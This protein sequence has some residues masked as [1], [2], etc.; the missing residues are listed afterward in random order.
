MYYRFLRTYILM[1]AFISATVVTLHGQP[2]ADTQPVITGA[3]VVSNNQMGVI[4]STP[5]IP[6]HTYAW[7]VTGGSVTSG[8]GTNQITVSWGSVG[9]GNLS[10]LETN[11]AASCSSTVAKSVVIQPLLIS[12]FYYTNTSCYGDV[13]SFWDSSVSDAAMPITNYYWT[14]GDGIT[15]TLQN[16]VH[17]YAG[18]PYN[19]TYNVMLVV[20]NSIGYKDTIYDAV[21]VNPNQFIP[22][23]Q[24]SS[25]IP[26]CTYQPVS[27]NSSAS[28]T[29]P[30]TGNIIHWDWNFGNPASGTNNTSN[31]ANPTHVFTSPGTYTVSMEITNERYCKAM[32]TQQVV[33]LESVPVAKYVY[34]SPTCLGNPVY[35]TNQS[36]FPTGKDIVRWIWDFADGTSPVVIDA[37]SNPN[38]VHIF[39]GLGPYHVQLKVINTLG[40]ADSTYKNIG[41]DP[42]PNSAFTQD[43]QCFGDTVKFTDAS[44]RN[45]GPVITSYYWNFDDTGSGFFNTST[46]QNPT[47]KFSAPGIFDIMMVTTNASGCPDTLIKTIEIH[48]SP[49]V[50]F[51]WTLG[52]ENNEV[53]F[54]IDPSVTNLNIIGNM[55]LWNF[56]DGS[57]GYG[58]NPIH[59]YLAGGYFDVTCTVTDTLGCKG[60]IMHTILIPS[61][62]VAF[63]AT[64]SPVCD[65]DSICVTDLSSVPTPPFGFIKTWI[66]D[67]G[68]G[69][70]Q[71]TVHFPDP[72]N[73]CHLYS[74][75]DTFT[76]TL[77]VIDNSGFNDSFT[78]NVIVL[79]NPVANFFTT[80]ACQN[81]IVQ[82]TD[83]ST[84]NGGGNVITWDWNFGDPGSGVNNTAGIPTPIHSFS[85]GDSIYNVRL[86]ITNFTGCSDTITKQVYVFPAPPVDFTF[87]TACLN[88]I[89]TFNAN[90]GVTHIDSIVTWS[91]N[92]GDGTPL[93]TDPVTTQHLYTSVGNFL[94]TLTV[95]DHHGCVNTISHM[96]HVNPLP[97][98]DFTWATPNCMGS[99]LQFTDLSYVPAPYL[100]YI[101]KWK[102][103]FGDGTPIQTI[104]IPGNPSL[105]HTFAG[106]ATNHTVR[107]TVWTGD[108]CTAFIE[109]VVTSLPAPI[110]N[111][112]IGTT[113][114]KDQVVQFTDLSQPNG[115][116]SIASWIWDFGDPASGG[117]NVSPLPSPTHIYNT[118]GVTYNVR[119]IVHNTNTCIDT[120]IK[121]VFIRTSP[122]VDFTYDTA[123]LNT[124]VH[125]NAN[126]GLTQIDSIT[127]WS[128]N[129]GD[130]SG[131][132]TDPVTTSH[133]YANVG[134]YVTTLT[135][136]DNHG[137]INT[138]SHTVKVN[139][140]PVPN[141]S[142]NAPV[143][144]SAVVHFTDLSTVI[145]GYVAKW[146]WDFNDGSPLLTVFIPTSPNVIHIFQGTGNTHV[147]R[148][149]VW[150]ND[151]CTEFIEKTVISIP[152]PIAIFDYAT[153]TCANQS[154]Q[155]NDFSQTNGGGNLMTWNWNFG[156][157]GSG[158]GNISALQNP[159]HLYFTAGTYS[160]TLIVT[161]SSDCKD[162][163]VRNI[164]INQLPIANFQADTVCFGTPTTFTDLS[165]PQSLNIVSYSWSFGDA[166]PPGTLPNPTHTYGAPGVYT[167]TLTIINSNGCT[168]DTSHLIL[169]NPLPTA[170]F[171]F[172]TPNCQGAIVSYTDYSTTPTGYI[173]YINKWVWNF[174]DGSP[175]V[176]INFPASPDITHTFTGVALSHPVTLTVTTTSGCVHSITHIVNSVPAPVANFTFST[177]NCATQ[178]TQ[179]TDQ[180]QPNG[181]GSIIAWSWDFGDP[182]S[183]TSNS[184]TT[185]SPSHYFTTSGTFNVMLIISNASNCTDTILKTVNINMLPVA[186][187]H[188]DTACLGSPTSFTNTSTANAAN[189]ITYTWDFGDGQPTGSQPN[190]T[191][192]YLN[193]GLYTVKLTI[194][195]S[196]GCIKDTSKLVQVNP[197]PIP[198][199]TYTNPSCV[200]APVG[201]LNQST[202]PSGY[203]GSIVRWIWNFDDGTGDF[204]INFPASANITHTFAGSSTFHTVRLTVKTSDSCTAYITHVVN[205]I[206]SPIAN[207]SYPTS[208]CEQ[209][210]TAFSDQS[211]P[212]GG[213]N[214]ISWHWDFDDPPSGSDNTKTTPNPVHTFTA[215]GSYDV[216]LIVINSAGCSDTIQKTVTVNSKP[217]ASFLADTVCFNNLT[218]FT[219]ASTSA[220]GSISQHLWIFGDGQQSTTTN[221]THLYLTPGT[222]T[223]TLTVTT[224]LG[225]TK[226]TTRNVLVI[227]KPVA[228]F[229][230]SAPTCAGIDSVLFTDF[231]SSQ[232]GGIVKWVWQFGDGSS[233]S[234]DFPNDPNVYHTY[235]TGGT[236]NV[237]LT[238]HTSDSCVGT[239]TNPVIIQPA[240]LP[241]F[242]FASTRCAQMPIQFNDLSQ[243]NGGSALTTWDWDFGDPASGSA[244]QSQVPSPV[245]I[246]STSGTFT[247]SLEVH[248]ASG[249]HDTISKSVSV[250]QAPVAQFTADTA[251]KGSATQ[252]TDASTTPAGNIIAW[253]WN[254]GDPASGTSNVSTIQSPSHVFTN[255]G[256]YTVSLTV[257]NTAT[258]QHDTSMV[259]PVNPR[260]QAM[261][262]AG[263]A[264]VLDSTHFTDLSIA[265]GS[266]V[267]SWHWN[268]GDGGSS[269]IQNP[270]HAYATSGTFNVTLA[271]TNLSNCVDSITIPVV[272]RPT[273]VAAF[274]YTNFFCPGG[275]VNFQDQSQGV[276]SAIVDRLWIFI[277][278]S[279][280]ISVNPQFS[281][282]VT[283]STYAVTLIVT[284][285]YGC[286][287]TI[288]DSVYVKPG[289]SFTFTSDTACHGFP[290]HFTSI[291]NAK[292][293]SLYSIVWTFGD[294][295]SNGSNTSYLRNPTH[296][297][298]QPGLYNV[299]MKA[300]N[301]NN[302]V[303]SLSRVVRVWAL[304]TPAFS[305]HNVQC[306]SNL[307]FHDSTTYAGSGTI[308]SWTWD[309]GDGSTPL[310]IPSPG[311]GDISH[312]YV[313]TGFYKVILK[314]TNTRG[315]YD[316]ISTIV[317]RIPCIAAGFAHGD[318]MICANYKIAFADTSL[319]V[320]LIGNWHW[321]WGDTKDTAYTTHSSTVNH[322]FTAGGTYSVKLVIDASFNGSSYKDSVT[323]NVIVHPTPKAL[324][325]N[326]GTCLNQTTIFLDTTTTYGASTIRWS[327]NFGDLGSVP[328]DTSTFKNPSHKYDTAGYYD[329]KLVV[330][331]RYGCKDSVT[332]PTRVWHIPAAHYSNT[333]ACSGNPTYFYDHSVLGDTTMSY[334]HW[335][336][337][338]LTAKVD[339]S[340]LKDPIF[341]YKTDGDYTTRLI[342]RDK[343][344]CLDTVDSLVNVYVTPVS[345]FTF[346][347]NVNGLTGKLL[348]DNQSIGADSYFWDFGNGETS[349]DQNP[350]VSYKQD[351]TYIIKLISSNQYQC[352]DTTYYKYDVLFKG[353]YIPNAFSPTNT[354]VAVR[355]FKPVG[356]NLKQYHIMVFDTW[357]H[358]LWES[359]KLDAQGQPEEGWDG[360]YNGE[361]LPQGVYM[362]KVSAIFIDDTV[363]QGGDIGQGDFNTLGT[364][365]LLR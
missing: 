21:Y 218:H 243:T 281:F 145:S 125:Y 123:C 140:K 258:C 8:A 58:Q 330:M 95:I 219:D 13:V 107:L 239:I 302:C 164:T 154:V 352:S 109:H 358:M 185:Q 338:D 53:H 25:T 320:N 52:G 90:S 156:D 274:T 17:Q 203:L 157:P 85:Y 234:V 33:I 43:S 236:Y 260:P 106:I 15:S 115:G 91:W 226:D 50:D 324:F 171:T 147:V 14:F 39:P 200:G 311:P 272:V 253:N 78:Q 321:Y 252:F 19:I 47:H 167:V 289:M 244:N 118:G 97:V 351:G 355:L 329:V 99:P 82:F 343:N 327:W 68:D 54:H 319:P 63:F 199:F 81:M 153:S 261:F 163:T 229:S 362:W 195:N 237:I 356:M 285:N 32:L 303:D 187:F 70:A 353:L 304:P 75:V 276:G 36:T 149:T 101:A 96:V 24:F 65:G 273:P 35:F 259:V 316:T 231:S 44:T 363:W 1:A 265:P 245:H 222:F 212:N 328:K 64:N 143:C 170:A 121:S 28:T 275:Q 79:P 175:Q 132:V 16:P 295:N 202:T 116:G 201:Y 155:F 283:D 10:L 158:S 333:V 93:S 251:C 255:E 361:Y 87:D 83:A 139:P 114:C 233:T 29:P 204:N 180:S 214:I 129:F 26:N 227:P 34:S 213:G 342:V 152:K 347:Q 257:T 89:L 66:W 360:K 122:P 282:P 247:V 256:T 290:T 223:V 345:S 335:N 62:P 228:N 354:N 92:F 161:N 181:G 136:T 186:N 294:P 3:Q 296:T 337:G 159:T 315:C 27:F 38:V 349:T 291:N 254:F 178:L 308:A 334:W 210:T 46:L 104:V 112:S 5:N 270:N 11:P 297:F 84:P 348:M 278:G 120:I 301:S 110:A 174:G 189:I 184:S 18:P 211:Q 346:T 277:P 224:N 148:L 205:S 135:V 130:G 207:F 41:V 45:G 196:N 165:V 325:S 299:Q 310:V 208:S 100:G 309:F 331:N 313:N 177:V 235:N 197:L 264:C 77:K 216:V 284:D 192:T 179:F 173:G 162:T 49:S 146:Q 168:K 61:I 31:L 220:S 182:A 6:G 198:A 105:L 314:I 12:Y 332:K 80:V 317:Q 30:G 280:S 59:T 306:D 128:W 217:V 103:D 268:F 322:T 246:F 72:P 183:G 166:T 131:L 188:A 40:C 230:A 307:Y 240:P 292:G 298:T 86:V 293:D 144:D 23:P 193:P 20:T 305:W 150:T 119:L 209:Q 102:W 206:P 57:F 323:R 365:I 172:T 194:V 267:V 42:S 336:F 9:T 225:C 94:T 326:P 74:I 117:N 169:V 151:S 113:T 111:F 124:L 71:D 7:T 300:W 250:S 55:I 60:S 160:V 2:C 232:H 359:V 312:L 241:N 364:V 339:T 344:G 341:Y 48:A 287:D 67:F 191:H 127:S 138:R 37:P 137:C 288:I 51:F 108:S 133:M 73:I 242:S 340:L 318:T 279:T 249:C 269:T 126:S 56:D 142:W 22:T 88:H 215:A 4:Y 76:I 266:M 286:K 248:N 221:P 263:S 141:F 357:G 350:I 190:P 271:V 238:V 134:T 262:E 98:P 69:T 176:Q